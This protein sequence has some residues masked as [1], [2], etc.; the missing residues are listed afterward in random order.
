MLIDYKSKYIYS[1]ILHST[2]KSLKHL[3]NI[4]YYAQ[5][6]ECKD[7]YVTESFLMSSQCRRDKEIKQNTVFWY[8]IEIFMVEC[9]KATGNQLLL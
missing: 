6:G 8:G 4:T 5:H 1:F 7:K 3:L 9:I 2:N